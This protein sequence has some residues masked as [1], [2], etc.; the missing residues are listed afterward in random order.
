MATI[1]CDVDGIVADIFPPWLA[2][3]NAAYG[4]ALEVDDIVHY[5]IEKIVRPEC[6]M[7]IFDIVHDP[8]F[9]DTVPPVPGAIEGIKHWERQGHTVVL[10][11]SCGSGAMLAAKASWLVRHEVA[12]R[13]AKSEVPAN[14]IAAH[15]T[16]RLLLDADLLVDD[17]PA[18]VRGWINTRH[19]RAITLKYALN[20]S[21]LKD[22]PSTFWNWCTRAEDWTE[23]LAATERYL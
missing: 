10:V 18:A 15:S 6:G 17:N 20:A 2:A 14:L 12:R 22:E 5:D 13:T 7:R 16:T 23:I 1:I 4:D 9:Y 19:R 21:L 11:T 3:Y 8:R